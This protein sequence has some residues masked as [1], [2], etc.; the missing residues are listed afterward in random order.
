MDYAKASWKVDAVWPEVG[1]E[2]LLPGCAFPRLLNVNGRKYLCTSSNARI[3]SV[4]RQD[5]D[6]WVLSAGVLHKD[7]DGRQQFY[8]WHD[9]N[10]DGKIQE[11]EYLQSQMTLPGF[12]LKYFGEQWLDDMS[13]L[14]INQNGRE[15]AN[16]EWRPYP[17]FSTIQIIN[18]GSNSIYNSGQLTVRRRFSK[19]LFVRGSY[20]Y[21]KSLDCSSN[22]GGTVS[23]NF[24]SAQDSRNLALER[25]RSDFDI[26]HT[27]AGSFLWTP[28]LSRH[29][30]ARDWQVSGTSTIYTG[31]PFTPRVKNY[32]YTNGEASRPDRIAKGTVPN[33]SPDLWYDRNA[34]PVVPVGSYRFGNSGR[35]I[36]DGPGTIS[37]NMSLSRRI[38]FAESRALQFRLESFNLPNHPNFNL[39][40]N[41]VDIS[42]GGTISRAKN[43]RNLQMG[44]RLEF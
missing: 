27:F 16:R 30:L 9:A 32:N 3:C 43:N 24:S 19:Q 26:G 7:V 18:D 17:T 35:N 33:P 23:Y 25:G 38:R 14:A 10:G 41:N 4:Y 15:Q 22:T 11:A 8:S 12:V 1:T 13:V 6:R 37:I 21:A 44:L 2:P 42:T 29:W 36:L 39:P 20:T 34:F 40:E 28:K 31:Q 5:G